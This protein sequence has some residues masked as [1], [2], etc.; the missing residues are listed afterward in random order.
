M[1]IVL[2]ADSDVRTIEVI[3]DRVIAALHDDLETIAARL[4]VPS[5]PARQLTVAQVAGRL[6]VARSTVYAHW[7]EWGGYKL[8]AGAKARIRFDSYTLPI[9]RRKAEKFA[10]PTPQ[11]IRS[12]KPRTRRRDLLG[13]APRFA[14]PFD[15]V[16]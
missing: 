5:E 3:A 7:H 4:A 14:Q 13:D 9:V 11:P 1:A 8:G 10:A 15:G 6:G 16:A 12:A 2:V